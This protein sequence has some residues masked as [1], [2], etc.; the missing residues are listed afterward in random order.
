MAK[1][2]PPT[3]D[4]ETEEDLKVFIENMNRPPTKKE[5]QMGKEADEIY[6]NTK[7]IYHDWNC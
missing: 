1:P 2:I 6:K 4:I 5:I 3:P 7:V